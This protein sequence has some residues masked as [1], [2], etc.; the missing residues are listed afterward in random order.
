V[1]E[2]AAR[3]RGYLV[4]PV[5]LP[6]THVT[7]LDWPGQG[8]LLVHL[9]EP[10]SVAPPSPLISTVAERLQP[11]YRVISLAREADQPYQ[12][13]AATVLSWLAQ[14]GF[15]PQIL[16]GE[17]GGSLTALLVAAWATSPP[18]ALGLFDADV[19]TAPPT[20]LR[21]RSLR[22]APPAHDALRAAV[23]CPL[24]ATSLL[25]ELTGWLAQV[26]I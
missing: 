15:A 18:S 17:R 9:P 6:A 26:E 8:G 7:M 23:P 20:S 13:D 5:E 10:A 25:D 22:A 1:G 2:S 16:V 21:A 12:A 3:L 19:D 4:R 24:F 14:F 11:R